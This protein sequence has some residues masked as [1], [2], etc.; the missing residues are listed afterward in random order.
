MITSL[1]IRNFKGW[2]DTGSLRL[3]PIT[4][5]F[6]TNSSGKS[7][8]GQFLMMLKQTASSP[9]RGQVLHPGDG[10]TAVVAEAGQVWDAV[11]LVRY[12]SREAFSRMV[13]DPEYL[14]ITHLRSD[15]LTEAVL[16]AT[17]PLF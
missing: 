7:S 14:A 4:V 15:A 12:P 11:L 16:Q 8:L 17:V 1:Q 5:F 13:A 2:S 10:S 9:D 6:G 3:A